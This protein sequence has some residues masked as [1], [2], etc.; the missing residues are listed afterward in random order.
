MT[1]GNIVFLYEAIKDES[2]KKSVAAYYGCSIKVFLNY[3]ETIRLVRN[4]CAHG[5][6]LYNL[7]VQKGINKL[8]ANVDN[9]ESHNIKGAIEVILHFI[10]IISNRHKVEVIKEIKNELSELAKSPRSQ[11]VVQKCANL[12]NF[13]E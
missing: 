8:P 5:G 12:P 7:S 10:G 3:L 4:R 2:L 9:A 6:C 1:L 11:A 13:L